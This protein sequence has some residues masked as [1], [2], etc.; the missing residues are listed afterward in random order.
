[1]RFE[2]Y[3]KNENLSHKKKLIS[4]QS[5]AV[6][7]NFLGGLVLLLNKPS[8]PFFYSPFLKKCAIPPRKNIYRAF[9]KLPQ[10]DHHL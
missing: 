1:M 6:M 10:H 5:L 2:D 7:H 4:M 3:T 8:L 9:M